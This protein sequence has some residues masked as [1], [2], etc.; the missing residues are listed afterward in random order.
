LGPSPLWDLDSIRK[1]ETN[2]YRKSLSAN[3]DEY[4]RRLDATFD[5]QRLAV[6]QKCSDM[7]E[8]ANALI[9]NAPF[10]AEKEIGYVT[11]D[12]INDIKEAIA[13]EKK[14]PSQNGQPA[15]SQRHSCHHTSTKLSTMPSLNASTI[16]ELW[17]RKSNSAKSKLPA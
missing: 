15:Q 12:T 1:T 17:T 9:E 11:K 6:N 3:T 4:R 2:N 16:L 7:E 5:K 10:E 8:L 13:M 14:N